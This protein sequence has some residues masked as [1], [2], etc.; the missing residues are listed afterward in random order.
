MEIC[1]LLKDYIP[2]EYKQYKKLQ[3]AFITKGFMVET[4]KGVDIRKFAW[5]ALLKHLDC[6]PENIQFLSMIIAPKFITNTAPKLRKYKKYLTKI[7][8]DEQ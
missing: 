3:A 5:D 4:E 8:K 2:S 6:F 1:R 7:N